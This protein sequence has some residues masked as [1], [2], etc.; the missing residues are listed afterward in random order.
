MI[1]KGIRGG[2]KVTGEPSRSPTTR[3]WPQ[4][5]R[6]LQALRQDPDRRAD[7][8]DHASSSP[9]SR[10]ATSRR[11]RRSSRSPAP[12][13]SAS[14][15]SRRSS[16][17]STRR[18][19][20]A[21]PTWRRARSG[22][23]STRSRRTLG[24]QGRQQVTARPPTSCSP[25]SRR[26]WTSPTPRSCRR[27]NLA[28]GAKELLDE[29][30]TGKITGEEDTFSHTDLWDFEANLEGSRA[31]IAALRPVIEERDAA[32]GQDARRKFAA[33]EAE[34]DK[35][36]NGDGWKLHNE[37]SEADAQGAR[38]LDQRAGRA[39]Q[40]GRPAGRAK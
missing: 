34:L 21:R 3:S 12:T 25:T 36:R 10:P 5:T 11:P 1:G 31:A 30:A 22:P 13:G 40:Q 29:V 28:N 37:L 26:S 38:R 35:H 32:P 16:A 7:R 19:T 18:S 24:H 17:T 2:F 39:D 20:P 8:Q 4:A 15:R 23:A 6:G 27:C 33:A 9:R 14:S